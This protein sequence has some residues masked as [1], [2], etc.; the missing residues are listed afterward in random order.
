MNIKAKIESLIDFPEDD[1]EVDLDIEVSKKI[2]E[3]I[4]DIS[5]QLSGSIFAEKLNNGFS[6][7]IV[8]GPNVGK[9]TLLNYLV[10]ENV[11][12]VSGNC[13]NYA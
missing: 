1:V 6:V 10:G 7:A 4:S 8:G 9:S 13:W 3:L 12:I 5:A 2:E 11:S